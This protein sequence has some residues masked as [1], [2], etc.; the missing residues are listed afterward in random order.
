MCICQYVVPTSA[1]QNP[2]HHEKQQGIPFTNDS[3]LRQEYL[4]HRVD[5]GHQL[6][7]LSLSVLQV[8]VFLLDLLAPG[9]EENW[10]C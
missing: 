7:P 9:I 1:V 6:D 4:V 3:H 10:T 2:V 5:H 8:L